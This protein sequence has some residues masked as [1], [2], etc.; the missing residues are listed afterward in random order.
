[1]NITHNYKGIEI[2]KVTQ[3]YF[4]KPETYYRIKGVSEVFWLLRDAKKYIDRVV[5]K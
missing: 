4:G 5:A 1:M 3:Y 2:T